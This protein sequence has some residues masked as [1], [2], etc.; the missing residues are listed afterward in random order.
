MWRC[1]LWAEI[2]SLCYYSV[3][4]GRGGGGYVFVYEMCVGG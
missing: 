4:R 2:G 1:G 3:G